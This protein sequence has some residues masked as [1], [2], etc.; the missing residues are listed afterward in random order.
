MDVNTKDSEELTETVELTKDVDEEQRIQEEVF[1]FCFVF[2]LNGFVKY[3]PTART[4]E[5]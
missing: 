3:L 5:R 1:L 2:C 4:S